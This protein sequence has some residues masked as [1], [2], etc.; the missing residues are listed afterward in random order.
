MTSVAVADRALRWARRR[1]G[2]GLLLVLPLVGLAAVV[3]LAAAY[4]SYVLWP[5][6]P[7]P[8]VAPDAPAL[9]I[10]VGEVTFN[11]PPGAIRASVQRKPGVQE[12]V[13][14]AFLWPSLAPVDTAKPLPRPAGPESVELK[15]IDRI[16]VTIAA[17]N[18]AL[19]PLD[20]FK[21]IYPRYTVKEPAPAFSGLLSL[22]FHDGTPYR[23]EELIYDSAAPEQFFL[24]CTRDGP[25]YIPGMCLAERRLRDADV[26]LRFPRAWLSDWRTVSSGLDRLIARLSRME[27]GQSEPAADA[28]R[29]H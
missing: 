12:R 19:S 6:W 17:S 24:R 22:A 23:G 2:Q 28:T 14:L 8:A 1:A 25:R 10:I 3:V 27:M 26:I 11:I 7:G 16:F 20:R 4:V 5:R 29:V 21:T 18:G 13:D 15:P 9:P